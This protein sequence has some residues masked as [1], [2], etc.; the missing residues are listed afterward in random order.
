MMAT[1]CVEGLGGSYIVCAMAVV[2]VYLSLAVPEQD[3][4]AIRGPLDVGQLCPLQLLTPDT[5]S[6]H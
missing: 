4:L 2:D 1:V 3:D 5:I 6:V